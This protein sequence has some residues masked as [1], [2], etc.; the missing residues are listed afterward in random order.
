MN[1]ST[2]VSGQTAQRSWD[3]F[4]SPFTN[5]LR[6]LERAATTPA[7]SIN[8]RFCGPTRNRNE[9]EEKTICGSA[10]AVMLSKKKKNLCQSG[11][12]QF[13]SVGH[14]GD[15]AKGGAKAMWVACAT[16]LSVQVKRR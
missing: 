13:N 11:T 7:W 4:I 5:A 16:K 8:S 3:S 12:L 2:S 14:S 9:F 1:V 6:G 15:D 10:H